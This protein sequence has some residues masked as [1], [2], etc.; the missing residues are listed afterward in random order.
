METGDL[1]C[2]KIGFQITS[3]SYLTSH[4]DFMRGAWLNWFI[5]CFRISRLESP[6]P[7][8]VYIASCLR[9][10]KLRDIS[11]TH[12]LRVWACQVIGN[13]SRTWTRRRR[14]P[15]GYPPLGCTPAPTCIAPACRLPRMICETFDNLEKRVVYN[16]FLWT[17]M[18]QRS[19]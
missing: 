11:K 7:R 8:H 13:T 19:A 2:Q 1:A 16:Y 10:N 18:Y 3:V 6:K 17:Y 5:S 12:L 14:P 4:N 9:R 15:R